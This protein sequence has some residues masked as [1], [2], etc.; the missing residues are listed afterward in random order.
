MTE[1][2]KPEPLPPELA[3]KRFLI[4]VAVRFAG[5]GCLFAGIWLGRDGPSVAAFAVMA[6]GLVSLFLRPRHL[7]LTR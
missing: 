2:L 4:F 1:S 5:L 7:G 3:R 6:P